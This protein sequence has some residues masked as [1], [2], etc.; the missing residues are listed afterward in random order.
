[1]DMADKEQFFSELITDKKSNIATV[2][3]NKLYHVQMFDLHKRVFENEIIIGFFVTQSKLDFNIQ[4]IHEYFSLKES[5][6]Q[7]ETNLPSPL[8]LTI[9]PN[10]NEKS[11]NMKLYQNIL[12]PFL[13]DCFGIFQPLNY[14]IQF[15]KE[16]QNE[17]QPLLKHTNLVDK[18]GINNF[19]VESMESIVS[20]IIK[21]IEIIQNN[22]STAKENSIKDNSQIVIDFGKE[23]K[24][25]INEINNYFKMISRNS[26]VSL[27]AQ[28]IALAQCLSNL[29]NSQALVAEKLNQI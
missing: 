24:K 10:F 6:F 8:I 7:S 18:S 22:I 19:Q 28:E 1:M 27:K 16:K 23:L 17:I 4:V 25:L 5:K 14:E 11:F 26:E 15:F 3:I 29:A 9:D 2:S 21:N 12:Q 13:N 20:Q